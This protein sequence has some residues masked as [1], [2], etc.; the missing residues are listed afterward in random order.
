MSY[1][2][3]KND[4]RAANVM[5]QINREQKAAYNTIYKPVEDKLRNRISDPNYVA[6]MTSQ[7]VSGAENAAATSKG[8]AAR[9]RQRY[10]I[11]ANN[12]QMQSINNA[13]NLSAARAMADASNSTRQAGVSLKTAATNGLAGMGVGHAQSAANTANSSAQL[14]KQ[15]NLANQQAKQQSDQG[16]MQLVGQGIGIAAG[17]GLL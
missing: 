10:G 16:D 17:A 14:E 4:N 1:G 13:G 9:T 5:A 3:V 7:S 12:R 8:I 2:K 11:T 6:N 15:R